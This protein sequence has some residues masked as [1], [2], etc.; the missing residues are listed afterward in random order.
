M[1]A[2]IQLASRGGLPHLVLDGKVEE[3]GVYQ[4]LVWRSQLAVVLE[5]ESSRSLLSV[6][7][8]AKLETYTLHICFFMSMARLTYALRHCLLCLSPLLSS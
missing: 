7:S 2:R 5:K 3:I 8:Q 1:N 4:H 6:H